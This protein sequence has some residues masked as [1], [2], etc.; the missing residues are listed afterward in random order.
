MINLFSHIEN[1]NTQRENKASSLIIFLIRRSISSK[2][3]MI[4]SPINKKNL[5]I[6][7]HPDDETL[8]CGGTLL[9]LKSQGARIYWLIV[10]NMNESKGFSIQRI[11]D[12]E[13][14]IKQINEFYGFEGIYQLNFPTTELDNIAF[15]DIVSSIGDVIGKLQPHT[16]MIPHGGDIHTDHRVVFN[17]C[18]ACSKWFRYSSVK[19]I[20]V[21]ET[22]SETGLSLRPQLDTFQPNLYIDISAYLQKKIDAMLIYQ[23]ELGDFPFPRSKKAIHAQASLHGANSGCN[24]AEAFMSVKEV[25]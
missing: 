11:Q 8:G 22:L 1:I 19:R 23:E 25:V 6:A 21:Y 4:I 20:W 10:T 16:L 13:K 7:P 5:V 18:S 15:N 2:L 14:Q 17:A 9:R 12:R 3:S 24:A